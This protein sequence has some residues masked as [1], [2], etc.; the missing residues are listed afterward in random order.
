M[1]DDPCAAD[2]TTPSFGFLLHDVSRLMRR[3]FEQH[4][5]HLGLTRAQW[6]AMIFLAKM[7]G[8]HQRVLA[9]ALEWE[10]ITLARVLDRLEQ[11]GYVERRPDEKDR[12]A[13]RLYLTPN[14]A[15]VLTAMKDLF[16]ATKNEATQH[17]TPADIE[18]GQRILTVMKSNLL[19]ALTRPPL[20]PDSSDE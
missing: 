19:D 6:Q 1:S 4:A 13:W 20:T 14:A 3:R 10:P 9:E 11:A 16:F 8:C 5:R 12:R 18:E 7:E 17:L 2:A 15:G